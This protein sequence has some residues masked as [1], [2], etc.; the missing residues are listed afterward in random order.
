MDLLSRSFKY[1]RPRGLLGA[2]RLDSN[3]YVQLGDEPNVAAG[4]LMLHEGL[5]A[6]GQN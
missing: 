1:H 6:V 2:R 5:E 4:R 3:V